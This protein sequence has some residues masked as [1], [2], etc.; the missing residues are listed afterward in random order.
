MALI[1][2]SASL[3]FV[4]FLIFRD[5]YHIFYYLL[6][7]IAF[8]PVE[9]LIVS[10]I[11]HKLLQVRERKAMLNKLNMVIG[12]FFSEVGTDLLRS[13]SC[14]YDPRVN[15]LRRH[16]K[17]LK[18]ETDK[19]YNIVRTRIRTYDHN[20]DVSKGK[21]DD[22]KSFLISKREFLLRLLENPNLLEHDGFTDLLWA[23]FHLTDEL[24]M[25][26]RFSELPQTDLIHLSGDIKRVYGHLTLEWLDYMHHLKRSYPYI[27][28]LAI[29]TNPFDIDA[30]PVVS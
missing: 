7:D 24:A 1:L 6:S 13:I 26:K 11:L 22:L 10:F 15:E 27:Y 4:H 16:L 29:R 14:V 20:V 21:L 12:T 30:S 28:S 19:Y 25:R 2:V 17:V 8:L 3:Y 9:V 23:V 18:T 5:K